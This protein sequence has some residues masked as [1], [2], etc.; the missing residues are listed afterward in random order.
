MYTK[1]QVIELCRKAYYD[2]Y[3]ALYNMDDLLP[4]LENPDK[5]S[6]Y[7]FEEWVNK[8]IK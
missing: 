5:W 7:D 2:G 4:I 8:N 6:Q 3:W 1:E